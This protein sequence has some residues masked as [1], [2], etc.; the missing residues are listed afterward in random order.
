MQNIRAM[1]NFEKPIAVSKCE[2]DVYD[3]IRPNTTESKGE[4]IDNL[5]G[6]PFKKEDL[7]HLLVPILILL[8]SCKRKLRCPCKNINNSMS[9]LLERFENQKPSELY[10]KQKRV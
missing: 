6:L 7:I 4:V 2:D 3:Y 9:D 8:K 10:F 1:F 5:V